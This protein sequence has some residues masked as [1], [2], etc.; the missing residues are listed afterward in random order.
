MTPTE[1]ATSARLS[2]P[3]DNLTRRGLGPGLPKS[4]CQRRR[5]DQQQLSALERFLANIRPATHVN[6]LRRPVSKHV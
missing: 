5:L 4:A 3:P 1:S 2:S 6:I